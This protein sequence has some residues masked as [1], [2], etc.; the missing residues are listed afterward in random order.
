M[1]SS[2]ES[3][4]IAEQVLRQAVQTVFGEWTALVLAIENEW[5][6]DGTRA[7]ALALLQKVED[8]MCSSPQIHADE[9]ED[10]L[11]AAL[12][13]DFNV[14]AEDESPKQVAEILA[15]LHYEARTPVEIASVRIDEKAREA[16]TVTEA[17]AAQSKR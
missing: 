10:L 8:G 16:T 12:I 15:R 7:K 17:I 11:D 14:E 13:D 3:A 1:A 2:S 4:A 9:L 5:G 6:G